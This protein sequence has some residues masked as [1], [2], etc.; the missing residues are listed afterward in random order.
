MANGTTIQ[1]RMDATTKKE[2]QGILQTLG[3]SM[4]EAVCIFF[5]QIILQRGIPFDIKIP[6]EVTAK[7]LADSEAGKG[8]HAVDG[9]DELFEDVNI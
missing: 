2:A 8:L 3:I 5:R 9:V 6:N 7:T 1:A 4:S